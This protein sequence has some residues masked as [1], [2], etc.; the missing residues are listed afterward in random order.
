MISQEPM[1]YEC[2]VTVAKPA[3]AT[4]F[5]ALAQQHGWKTSCIDGDPLLGA[6]AFFYFT[7][8]HGNYDKI[9]KKMKDLVGLLG[10]QVIREKIEQI[11]YDTKNQREK[12]DSGLFS[13][14]LKEP[15]P[16]TR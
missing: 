12:A 1:N 6:K 16:S 15:N 5:K 7:C 4:E 13:T 11:I 3:D 2:H 14:H 10:G 8:H 9:F